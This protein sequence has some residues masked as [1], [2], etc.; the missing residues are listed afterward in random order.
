VINC[1]TVHLRKGGCDAQAQGDPRSLICLRDS[2]IYPVAC[3]E[4]TTPGVVGQWCNSKHSENEVGCLD[5]HGA[6]VSEPDALEH[7]AKTIAMAM[8]GTETA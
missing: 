7:W 8:N 5:C 6:S 4:N 1:V 3:Y 2:R